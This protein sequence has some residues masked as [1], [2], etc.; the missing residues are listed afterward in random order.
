MSPRGETLSSQHAARIRGLLEISKIVR[1]A[2]DLASK[3]DRMAA[4]I[5]D[6]LGFNTV[7]VNLHRP[8]WD[9]FVVAAV[10]GT[11]AARDALLGRSIGWD[12]WLPLLDPRWERDG[13]YLILE[14]DHDWDR[15]AATY[16]P[17]LPATDDPDL[18][19]SEDALLVPLRAADGHVLGILAVDEPESGRRPT[20]E[21]LQ[22]LVAVAAHAAQAIESAQEAEFAAGYR[23]ALE[24]LLR[25]SSQLVGTRGPSS[26]LQAVCDAVCEALGFEVA[27]I[28]LA[29]HERDRYRPVAACGLD[30]SSRDPHID[31]PIAA[32]NR[33]FEP[34]FEREG[35]YLLEREQALARV[36]AEPKGFESRKNGRGPRAWNRH[37]LAAPW[38]DR[39]GSIAGYIWVDDPTDRLSPSRPRLQALRLLANQ[40]ATA[41]ESATQFEALQEAEELHGTM[42]A[43]SPIG[44]VSLD[45]EG[46]VRSW[47]EAARQ[48]FGYDDAEVIGC[49][50]PWIPADARVRF[51]EWFAQFVARG[52]IE[53][54]VYADF[55]ADGTGIDVRTT[56]APVRDASGAV[57]GVI[58]AIED[59]TERRRAAVDLERRNSE[60][61]ALHATTLDLLDR[62]ETGSTLETIV[63]RAAELLDVRSG[64]LW[65]GDPS[66]EEIY[67]A[68][69]V[70]AF[71]ANEG[72]RLARGQGLAGRIW[73]SGAPLTLE[74][75]S[76]W[77]GHVARYAGSGFH[78]ATG[79]PLRA[80]TDVV[81]V[82]AV[83]SDEHGR[84]FDDAE[85][86]LLQRFAH[87]ASLALANA[88]LL[89]DLRKSQG[90]YRAIVENS[91]DVMLLLDLEGRM[92]YASPSSETVFGY[93]QQ[94]LFELPPFGLVHPDDLEG[95][96]GRI[97]EAVGGGTP[98][99]YM[100]RARHK[101]GRW[102][103][104]EGVPAAVR[105]EHGEPEMVL[106][107]AR[108]VS[109]RLRQEEVLRKTQELYRTVV[110]N[111]RDLILLLGLDGEVQYGSPAQRAMLGYGDEFV[112]T[113]VL[114]LVAGED[115]DDMSHAIAAALSGE[116]QSPQRARMRRHDGTWVDVEALLAPV[117]GEDGRPA[118]ILGVVRDTRER[119]ELEE[120]LRQ[121][122]KMEAVGQLAG[123]IAH[124]FNNL[125]T[126]ITGYGDLAL[127]KLDSTDPV[128]RNV[129]EMRRAGERAAT[130]T[131]QLLAFSRRQVL[132]PKVLNLNEAVEDMQGMLGRVLSERVNLS[133]G[134]ADDLG[135]TR[136]DPGQIEQVLMNLVINAR[137]AMPEGGCV[138]ITTA[139]V[140][141]D[142]LFTKQHVGATAGQYVMLAVSDTGIGMERTTLERVFDPFFTTKPAGQGTGLGLSTVYGIVKQTGGQIWAYSE[143]GLG[144]TFKVYLPRVWERAAEREERAPLTRTGGSETVLLVEDEDI[145]R[146][147]VEEML[148]DDGYAV[149]AA[150]SGGEA[151]E[152]A[153][154]HAAEID[155][156]VT[157]IVMPGL[158]GQQL[159]AQLVEERPGLRVLFASGYAEDAIATHGVLR[160]GTAFL[161]KPFTAPELATT[162]R[163]LL[164]AAP[165]NGAR[166][167]P[168][169]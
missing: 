85:L 60:L 32:L 8:E 103:W 155:V 142:E 42:L 132:Q 56:S 27:V 15:T 20:D 166:Q 111:S 55:R 14:G 11:P 118:A 133:T 138:T 37:W 140:T 70:G 68:V 62:H 156:L 124:D 121:S 1:E 102:V 82:L 128:Y 98:D 165:S 139:N 23:G 123:G 168:A 137:D 45:P 112:G 113:N 126:A 108:D 16:I 26:I 143:P 88:R 161:E 75:Y 87:L 65:L 130:L 18:W 6:C 53:D 33:L 74:D 24:H 93:S 117:L 159:A 57:T 149:L 96:L 125:L 44:I 29:D 12:F 21:D 157:D 160:P 145:V 39:D 9:D 13:A 104:M 144:T 40:A 36:Q 72:D 71:V 107:V 3:L 101:D 154:T 114:D 162:L 86:A 164:D 66:G 46:R 146:N 2:G 43:A 110:E 31:A 4:A 63:A 163:Q 47:N 5:A 153:R 105:N 100:A 48:M 89:D 129:E 158:S 122:Q 151:L 10:S 127:A 79:V 131:R 41:L 49:R 99:T 169:A 35:C 90:L 59:I 58:A 54:A 150:A 67:V 97:A 69:G 83:A 91:I 80:G 50:P 134:L 92:R 51:P 38:H 116:G 73:E 106:V 141:L 167:L 52:E 148:A 34:E 135:F 64:C 81:G 152:L 94:E 78:A 76:G 22:L 7:A 77:T 95:A 19:H 84:T 28:E 17:E 61:E 147:L 30:L 120:Q 25:I 119:R 136:A 115:F 109:D